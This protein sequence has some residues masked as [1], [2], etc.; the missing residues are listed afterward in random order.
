[1]KRK[2]R[3]CETCGK[4]T[5]NKKYC[6]DRC[7]SRGHYSNSHEMR[8]CE[9]CK[10]EFEVY[11]KSKTRFCSDECRRKYQKTS[12]WGN[13]MY[14]TYKKTMLEKYGVENIYQTKKFQQ[15]AK[16]TK[17][18][19]YGNENYN[20]QE[21]RRQTCFERYDNKNYVNI[22]KIIETNQKRHGC[23]FPF[24]TKEGKQKAQ[25][26][27]LERY[28]N[29]N[30]N[31]REKYKETCLEKYGVKNGYLLKTNNKTRISKPQREL[32]NKIKK[33]YPDAILEHYIP[34]TRKIVDIYIPS[35]NKVIEFYGKYW[36]CHPKE[37]DPDYY[38]PQLHMTAK[39]K[40]KIDKERIDCIKKEGY[41]VEII[42]G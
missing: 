27:K 30:Y 28:G 33:E 20:N 3:K 7:R 38:H 14:A 2:E 41:E 34:K 40:W 12:E 29:E 39:E 23:D 25:Q 36:H 42:W 37:F 22:T 26:T 15:K 8:E 1:M 35:K 18:K 5:T 9:Y 6:S 17:L 31:N 10:N 13:K 11:K 16:E 24:A 4:L 21:K 32:Y 19:R